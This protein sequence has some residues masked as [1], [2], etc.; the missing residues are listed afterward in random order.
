MAQAI[1]ES[2]LILNPDGSVYHLNLH[3]EELAD[4]VILVGDPGRVE[5]VS[6]FFDWIE[7][8][9]EKREF[10]THTGYFNQQ[11]ISVLSTGIGTDNI[12]IVLNELDALVN[13]D[14]KDQ[15]IKD[16]LESLN[17]VRFGT[18]GA[19]QKDI[20]VDSFVVSTHGI[21]L[22]ILMSYYKPQQ[23][24]EE[25]QLQ[26]A[27][28]EHIGPYAEQLRPYCSAGTRS[29]IECFK[30]TC[31]EGMTA[32]GC[33]FYAPQGRTLRYELA[34]PNLLDQLTSFECNGKRMCNF[35]M[36]TSA[37]YGLGGLLGHN[38]CSINLIIC[39]RLAEKVSEDME[40]SM[41][42][43]ILMALEQLT[44]QETKEKVAAASS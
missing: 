13:I 44:A 31:I 37:I 40:G 22:D 6:K 4:T 1:P 7:V 27:F 38:S 12:D 19:L 24:D 25:K 11:R 16:E 18:S 21:G 33:G 10:I 41:D 35:E 9:K 5:A 26:K 8:K 17:F 43:M 15:T 30:D 20:P 2:Q 39:N 3:P 34:M 28:L 36:E 23:T 29:L 14:L 32:T 42:K